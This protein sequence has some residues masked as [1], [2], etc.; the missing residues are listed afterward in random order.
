MKQYK[1]R[2]NPESK[3]RKMAEPQIDFWELRKNRHQSLRRPTAGPAVLLYAPHHSSHLFSSAKGKRK[4]T[5]ARS[6]GNGVGNGWECASRCASCP[7]KM[8]TAVILW[9]LRKQEDEIDTRRRDKS[10][11]LKSIVEKRVKYH[12][13]HQSK[14]A[15][16]P[17]STAQCWLGKRQQERQQQPTASRQAETGQSGATSSA[18]KAI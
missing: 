14:A 11:I 7:G 1:S 6:C 3:K 8:V 9:L 13:Y 15:H 18:R 4:G 12:F 17:G 2:S 10:D 5:M 16:T